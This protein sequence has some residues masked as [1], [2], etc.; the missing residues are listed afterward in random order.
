MLTQRNPVLNAPP[1]AWLPH[2]QTPLPV[3]LAR[4]LW[5]LAPLGDVQCGPGG[6][7]GRNDV[8]VHAA[9]VEVRL[10]HPPDAVPDRLQ[11]ADHLLQ[12]LALLAL[13]GHRAPPRCFLPR[14]THIATSGIRC[15]RRWERSRGAVRQTRTT[16]T[17]QIIVG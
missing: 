13:K 3:R 2:C 11:Q 17:V 4:F 10:V 16:R 12:N 6:G 7:E 5:F 15:Y 9:V 1:R 8:P 14:D